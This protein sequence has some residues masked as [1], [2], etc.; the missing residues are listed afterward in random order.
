MSNR[1]AW[2]G[3]AVAAGLIVAALFLPPLR[4]AI[5]VGVLLAVPGYL[6][7][8]AVVGARLSVE[9]GVLLGVVFSIAIVALGGVGMGVLGIRISAV[10]WSV[11]IGLVVILLGIVILSRPRLPRLPATLQGFSARDLGF[12]VAGLVLVSL[13]LNVSA[14]GAREAR[15][16]GQENLAELWITPADAGQQAVTVGLQNV[17]LVQGN[18]TLELRV[19]DEVAGSFKLTLQGRESWERTFPLRGAFGR[20]DVFLYREGGDRPIRHVWRTDVR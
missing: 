6:L 9:E 20:V 7:A 2:V 8:L 17:G 13:A 3:L 11:Y 4:N 1:S 10:S 19:N 14:L 12:I 15:S 18:Y 5:L 16:A